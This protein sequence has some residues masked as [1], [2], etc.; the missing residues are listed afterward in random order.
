MFMFSCYFHC[1]TFNNDWHILTRH[2]SVG[3]IFQAEAIGYKFLIKIRRSLL[4]I[5]Y[6]K[7]LGE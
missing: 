7:T 4:N 3:M 1:K 6:S 2:T 5:A